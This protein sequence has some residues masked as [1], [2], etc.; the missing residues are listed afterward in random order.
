M[1]T[2]SPGAGRKFTAACLQITSEREFAPNIAA[3]GDLARRARDAGAEFIMTPEITAMFEPK[4]DQ[5]LAKATDEASN[6]ALAAFRELAREVDAWLLVG[7]MAI[8]LEA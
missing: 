5:H 3:V 8:K 1:T 4:R 7:S 6:P 2:M